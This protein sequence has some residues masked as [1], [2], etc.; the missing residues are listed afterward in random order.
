VDDHKHNDDFTP[1]ETQERFEATLREVIKTPPHLLEDFMM[2]PIVTV[3]SFRH[4]GLPQRRWPG[5]L[6]AYWPWTLTALAKNWTVRPPHT[7]DLG[8]GRFGIP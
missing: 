6:V 1:Q 2:V 7:F 8:A 4:S 3:K 5:F